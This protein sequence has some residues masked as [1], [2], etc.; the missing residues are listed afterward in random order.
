VI[1]GLIASHLERQ[2]IVVTTAAL[3]TVTVATAWVGL[4]LHLL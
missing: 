1:P 2:G 4:L 3:V